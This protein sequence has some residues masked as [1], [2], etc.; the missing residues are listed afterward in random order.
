[1]GKIINNF[2]N[3]NTS[4]INVLNQ[5]IKSKLSS[6]DELV[7]VDNLYGLFLNNNTFIIA[8]ENSKK[9]KYCTTYTLENFFTETLIAYEVV[10]DKT[11]FN[12]PWKNSGIFIANVDLHA[13][14]F[15]IEKFLNRHI[16]KG[17]TTKRNITALFDA[18]NEYIKEHPNFVDSLF[19]ETIRK[20]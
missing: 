9:L 3:T 20:R 13:I 5:N 17:V 18:T 16:E 6:L 2:T 11:K 12:V 8:Q 15:P 4:M 10:E 7:R 14:A 1:M 19:V